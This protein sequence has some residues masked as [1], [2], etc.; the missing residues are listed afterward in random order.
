MGQCVG[1]SLL[2]PVNERRQCQAQEKADKRADDD[3]FRFESAQDAA[4]GP[5]GNTYRERK[6]QAHGFHGT[7]KVAS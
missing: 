7:K 6:D 2:G 5:Q 1:S 3:G 4:N